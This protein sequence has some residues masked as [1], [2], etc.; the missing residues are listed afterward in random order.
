MQH[1]K[2]IFKKHLQIVFNTNIKQVKKCYDWSQAYL[3]LALWW[4]PSLLFFLCFSFLESS[5]EPLFQWQMIIIHNIL[6]SV[7]VQMFKIY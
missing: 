6:T 7:S 4:D 5:R 2:H 1:L 3:F